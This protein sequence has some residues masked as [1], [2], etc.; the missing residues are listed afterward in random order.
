MLLCRQ[1]PA[2]PRR[3][4]AK[5]G[6]QSGVSTAPAAPAAGR[7]EH[8]SETSPAP[9]VTAQS[10]RHAS[11]LCSPQTACSTEMHLTSLTWRCRR[12]MQCSH[13]TMLITLQAIP[14]HGCRKSCHKSQQCC[15]RPSAAA[16]PQLQ[17]QQEKRQAVPSWRRRQD[18]CSGSRPARKL[19]AGMGLPMCSARKH[20][21]ARPLRHLQQ[22]TAGSWPF[23]EQTECLSQEPQSRQMARHA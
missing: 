22:M 8:P 14:S 5:A 7:C 10:W 4:G 3:A 13:G 20:Q 18:V 21:H 1:Q 6:E 9:L 12:I 11:C 16:L 19:A 23:H 17:R 15:S 2:G